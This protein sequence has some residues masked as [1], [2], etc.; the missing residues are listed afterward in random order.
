[1]RISERLQTVSRLFLDTAPIIYY[2]EASPRYLSHVES[3]FDLLDS[4]RLLAVA[5]PITLAECLV[6]PYRLSRTDLQQAF[7]DLLSH[8]SNLLFA[9]IDQ[10]AAHVAAQLRAR[11]N[12]TLTDAFQVAVALDNGCDA[13]LTNDATLKRINDLAV[14]VLDEYEPG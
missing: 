7:S 9:P 2:V 6:A 11:H 4:G 8:N 3:V 1:M 12:L 13:F 10:P 14:L 5:S